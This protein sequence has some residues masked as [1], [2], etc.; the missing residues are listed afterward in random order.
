MTMNNL[1]SHSCCPCRFNVHRMVLA[2][3]S[4]HIKQVLA[5]ANEDD[6]EAAAC[7]KT[8]TIDS[9]NGAQL[10]AII[11]FCYTSTLGI[12]QENIDGILSIAAYLQIDR[13]MELCTEY[14]TNT[15]NWS[16]CLSIWLL[17]NRHSIKAVHKLASLCVLGG[18]KKVVTR[19]EFKN[20]NDETL[21]ELLARD[22][23]NVHSEEQVFEAL[24]IWIAHD[25]HCR[26]VFFPKLFNLIR[27]DQMKQE[28][29]SVP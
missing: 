5:T 9:A 28:V 1:Y 6:A 16:N 22:D 8:I 24:T 17:A 13:A 14:L 18:F 27:V 20:I 4:Q 2:A 7:F 15:L 23:I 10:Q 3:S 25:V 19:D 21:A 11:A 26:M 12:N 29:S